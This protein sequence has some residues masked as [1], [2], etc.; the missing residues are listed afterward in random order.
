MLIIVGVVTFYLMVVLISFSPYDP[1]WSQTAWHGPIHNLGGVVGAWLADILFFTFGILAYA[2]PTI[3]L[4]FVWSAFIQHGYLDFY[5]LSLRLIGS[6]A[7]LLT[8]CGLAALNFDDLYYFTSGGVIGNLLSN[9]PWFNGIGTTT[10]LLFV[11]AC[12]LT[13]FTGWSWLT[14]AEKIGVV[15]LDCLTFISN[16]S[17]RHGNENNDAIHPIFGDDYPL[18]SKQKKPKS[19]V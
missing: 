13:L 17:R 4:F 6:L 5:T 14:I 16:H 15:V 3:M 11:W 19:N 7:L 10:L 9:L 12:G 2:I 1:S 18:K 8:S